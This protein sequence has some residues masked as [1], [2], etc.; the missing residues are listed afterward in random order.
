MTTLTIID[1]DILIDTGRDV[2]E[3]TAYLEHLKKDST[4]AISVVTQMELIV[5]CRDKNELRSTERFLDLFEIIHLNEQISTVAVDLLRKY[6]LSHGLLVADALIAA[7]AVFLQ[8]PFVSKNQKDYRFIEGLH[9]L[10]YL[11]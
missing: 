6:R 8:V 5:G 10:P 7:T 3:A 1:S 4:L 11:N 2:K 9:L